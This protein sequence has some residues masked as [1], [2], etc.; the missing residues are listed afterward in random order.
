MRIALFFTNFLLTLAIMVH[1]TDACSVFVL[2]DGERSYYGSNFDWHSGTGY[3]VVNPRGL[4]KT[5]LPL[6]DD[7][8]KPLKWES[9]Y[10]SV[11]FVQYGRGVPKGGI[12]EAGLVIEGLLLLDTE[13]PPPDDGPYVGS[14]SLYKQYV[15]DTCATV[16]DVIERLGQIRVAAYNWAPGV[17]F[18]VADAGG[19]CAVIAF[20]DGHPRV[21]RN[22]SLP[23][24]AL[25]NTPYDASLDRQQ[26]KPAVDSFGIVGG[27]DRF[28]TITEQLN[29]Y[30][31]GT[32]APPVAYAMAILDHV[33]AGERTQWRVVYDQQARKAYWRCR[34]DEPLRWIDLRKINFSCAAPVLGFPVQR[35]LSG[36]VNAHL[37][38]FTAADNRNLVRKTMEES[39]YAL[40]VPEA[41]WP[42]LWQW[43]ERHSCRSE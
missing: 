42:L 2:D 13:Y 11:T 31:A 3:V 21:F 28:G 7:P 23:V 36:E 5:S 1:Q 34:P 33:S 43:P 4:V 26:R 16:G 37:V 24:K 40:G 32:G 30:R 9:T 41:L 6:P 27:K 18:M 8:G 10:G 22:H 35:P 29:L 17:H 19:D 38:S 15:L 39:R 12:N 20:L 25:V 14:T